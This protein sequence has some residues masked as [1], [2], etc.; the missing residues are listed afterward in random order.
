[1]RAVRI[2][3]ILL[4]VAVCGCGTYVPQIGEIWDDNSGT[5]ARD[6]E[7]LIKEKV[8]CEL[9]RAVTN[10]NTISEEPSENVQKFNPRTGLLVAVHPLPDDWGVQM[11]LNLIVEEVGSLNPGVT[12]AD[13][14]RPVAIF[15]ASTSQSFSVGVGGTLSSDATRTDKFS[16]YYLVSDLMKDTTCAGGVDPQKIPADSLLL[17]SDLGIARWLKNALNVWYRTGIPR[18]LP[19]IASL[20]YDIKFDVVTSAYGLPGWKLARVATGSGG[21]NLLTAK[22]ERTHE[23]ILTFG[24]S[25]TSKPGG[26][27]QPNPISLNSALASEI[28]TAVGSAVSDVLSK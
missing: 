25:Q 7:R 14:L 11:Q 8:Y 17:Q 5:N 12:F 20:S 18:P 9:Q 16:L 15:G 6:I 28:G 24:P 22:R 26:T 4:C 19:Q 27:P 21:L 10:V 23:M 13:P 1:M 2:V 3:P